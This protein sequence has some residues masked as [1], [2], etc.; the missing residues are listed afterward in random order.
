MKTNVKNN[1]QKNQKR[2]YKYPNSS[3]KG[4]I[5]L[6]KNSRNNAY[7]EAGHTLIGYL[8]GEGIDWVT[9]D[10]KKCTFPSVGATKYAGGETKNRDNVITQMLFI[11][12]IL[13]QD[14]PGQRLQDFL[15]AAEDLEILPYVGD[16]SRDRPFINRNFRKEYPDLAKYCD[17]DRIVQAR[18]GDRLNFL[19]KEI[20]E[21]ERASLDLIANSLLEK[22]T[23]TGQEVHDLLNIDEQAKLNYQRRVDETM[24]RAVDEGIEE[25]KEFK[26]EQIRKF[27]MG[28]G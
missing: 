25:C 24:F 16:E 13:G 5:K 6:P 20:I 22:K 1:A 18:I 9:I 2:S 8:L 27:M 3:C 17:V 12:G 23:L 7:H 15:G 11:A 19:T 21:E 4:V 26:N 10:P 14:R 28:Q